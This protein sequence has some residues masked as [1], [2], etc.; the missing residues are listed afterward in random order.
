MNEAHGN[1]DRF[2]PLV[3]KIWSLYQFVGMDK[4]TFFN[5]VIDGIKSYTYDEEGEVSFYDFYHKAIIEITNQYIKD[6]LENKD[7][8]ILFNYIDTIWKD[9]DIKGSISYKRAIAGL[10]R[11][12]SLLN[13]LDFELGADE[14]I[15]IIS[16][17]QKL[18]MV[19]D[20]VI[21]KDKGL[22]GAGNFSKYGKMTRALVEGYC[23]ENGI[24]FQDEVEDNLDIADDGLALEWTDDETTTDVQVARVSDFS[25]MEFYD[26]LMREYPVLKPDEVKTLV[27]KMHEGDQEAKDKLVYSNLKLVI[28][29]AKKYIGRG[30]PFD[31][32]VQEGIVGLTKGIERF[33]LTKN[34]MLSTYTTW[35]IRQSIQRYTADCGRNIRLPVHIVERLGRLEKTIRNLTVEYGREPRVAEIAREMNLS[36]KQVLEL[37]SCRSDT[38][39]LNKKV[40][41]SEDTELERFIPS[42]ENLE[43]IYLSPTMKEI[44]ETCKDVGLKENELD[45][46]I[47]HLAYDD[48]TLE[49]LGQKYGVTRERIRQI[50]EK[51]L[52]KIARSRF[53][54]KLAIYSSDPELILGALR[55]YR[56]NRPTGNYKMNLDRIKCSIREEKKQ[57][58]LPLASDIDTK[59]ATGE[60]S[61]NEELVQEMVSSAEKSMQE[62]NLPKKKRRQIRS[63][64]VTVLSKDETQAILK[65][66]KEQ[67]TVFEYLGVSKE[68]YYKYIEPKL[69]DYNRSIIEK[70]FAG[71][72]ARRKALG[73]IQKF[74]FYHNIVPM[75]K[76][77]AEEVKGDTSKGE[78]CFDK[79]PSIVEDGLKQGINDNE[80]NMGSIELENTLST[81]VAEPVLQDS[82]DVSNASSTQEEINNQRRRK[83]KMSQPVKTIFEYLGVSSEDY[84]KYIEPELSDNDKAI[85]IG[86]YGTDLENPDLSIKLNTKE[87][88]PF[89]GRVVPKMKRIAARAGLIEPLPRRTRK[90]DI[91]SDSVSV[92]LDASA[93][94]AGPVEIEEETSL[95]LKGKNLEPES[96]PINT[97]VLEDETFINDV[98]PLTPN[99]EEGAEPKGDDN[100]AESQS[101]I[102]QD[103]SKGRLEAV[104]GADEKLSSIREQDL[105]SY[106]ETLMAECQEIESRL[107]EKRK[108]LEEAI[109]LYERRERLLAKERELDSEIAS[110]LNGFQACSKEKV[111]VND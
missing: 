93:K 87:G 5:F 45:I 80:E 19:M 105:N 39:S 57:S 32:L 85:I 79:S 108:M 63:S 111:K 14:L 50:E 25:N 94:K 22:I 88:A 37:Y 104:V 102:L 92:D 29:V 20:A 48:V 47:R 103:D 24:S 7:Y 84:Y 99:F 27:L 90:K 75:L 76:Q 58:L 67:I 78:P 68:D 12:D 8:R 6:T 28:S 98:S 53:S 96:T 3:D 4:D 56:R 106:V 11:I 31:D 16:T 21:A 43:G 13:D 73:E 59:D 60:I 26:Q 69:S 70:K 66:R 83:E 10:K 38:I 40:D 61:S 91:T 82:V 77:L 110:K 95:E 74:E 23:I 101:V 15:S 33:D 62:A 34:I 9:S 89:Y 44:I 64:R 42:S 52:K 30:I 18:R 46:I 36:E 17:N 107:S 86:R 81:I 97:Q 49:D 41:D 51:A 55:Q 72:M 35:W 1:I 71:V 109:S 100:I 65:E 2:I 54:E